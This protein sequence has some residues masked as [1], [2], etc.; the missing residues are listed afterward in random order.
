MK[1]LVIRISRILSRCFLP[2]RS[3][4]SP[5]LKKKHFMQWYCDEGEG[6]LEHL[7]Q[8]TQPGGQKQT[9]FPFSCTVQYAI[10]KVQ[11]QR[12]F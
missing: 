8:L 4:R 1:L 9:K 12:E 7:T 10:R 11:E 2:F 6:V 5:A 3:K